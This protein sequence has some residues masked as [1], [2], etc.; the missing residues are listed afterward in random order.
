MKFLLG[1]LKDY[2]KESFLA[3]LFKMLEAIFELFVPLV[4]AAIIDK[5]IAGGD[6]AYVIRMCGILVALAVLGLAF[7]IT[8]QFFAAKAA[9]FAASKM[10]EDLFSHIM[11]MSER[12]HGKV[13]TS[14]LITRI[15]SDVN[16]IQNGINLFLRLFLRSPFIVVGAFI[17]A[18]TISVKAAV[19]FAVVIALLGMIVYG[20]MKTTLPIF[21]GVQKQMEKIFLSVGENLEGARVIRAFGSQTQQLGAFETQ[22]QDLYNMQMKAGK[23]SALLN[24]ATYV[25]VNLGVVVILLYGANRVSLGVLAKGEVVALVNYMSQILVELIKLA[26]LIVVLMRSVPSVARLEEVMSMQADERKHAASETKHEDGNMAISFEHVT[27]AYPDASKPALTDISFTVEKHQRIGI[28][29]GTGAGKS[30]LLR[31]LSHRYD[32]GEGHIRLLGKDIACYTDEELAKTIGTV[33]QQAVLFTGSIRENIAFGRAYVSEE[34]IENAILWAQAKDVTESKQNGLDEE[35]LQDARNFSGGQRQR[36]TIARALAGKP[37]IIILDDAASALDA[38]TDARL[39]RDLAELPWKP[40]VVIVSQRA[41][42]VMDA[43]KILVLENGKCVGY[44]THEE[45]REK[46]EVYREIYDSQF[47]RENEDGK[48]GEVQI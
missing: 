21:S 43:D 26:N 34:D 48:V 46:N 39:R 2:K 45:L 18:G 27:F 15:T 6:K 11:D 36:L 16:Q 28:I 32:T 41:S 30:T 10:R 14:A 13:G 44:G 38:A 19:I 17:M 25:I 20:I 35:V 40:T 31:L 47:P 3:P 37:E 42:S 8:A 5:G 12:S 24:P 4:M 23:I 9:I 33:F 7:A 29:G 1:Y 22:T